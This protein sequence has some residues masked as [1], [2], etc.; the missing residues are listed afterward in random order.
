MEKPA[1]KMGMKKR[2]GGIAYLSGPIS[3][4][5]EYMK[6]FR[7]GQKTLERLGW[8]VVNPVLISRSMPLEAFG[9]QEWDFC[10]ALDMAALRWCDIMFVLPGGCSSR[11]AAAEAA[12]AARIGLRTVDSGMRHWMG[13]ETAKAAGIARDPSMRGRETGAE[14]LG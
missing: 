12:E 5:P 10:M 2:T 7:K 13:P 9:S 6:H 1:R 8:S 14:A 11:G 4:D 3:S